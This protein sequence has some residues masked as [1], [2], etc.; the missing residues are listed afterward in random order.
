MTTKTK[1]QKLDKKEQYILEAMNGP[2]SLTRAEAEDR[3]EFDMYWCNSDED[4]AEYLR[5]HCTCAVVE[6]KEVTEMFYKTPAKQTKMTAKEQ[7]ANKEASQADRNNKLA[8]LVAGLAD[9][10]FLFPTDMEVSDKE[11]TFTD[12]ETG[13]G[14][15][16]K[17]SKH[18]SQ[19]VV[20][21][22]VK[23]KDP[24]APFTTI[25]LRQM[26]IQNIMLNNRE[27]FVAPSY[28]G[29]QFGGVLADKKYPF[30]S[31]RMTHHKN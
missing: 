1:K 4:C 15:T 5:N 17:F 2:E 14:V 21:K 27:T 28:A 31:F 12:P 24:N 11:I 9:Y 16:I 8:A 22:E 23:R 29:S 10:P 6:E 25:E 30:Y 3:Y 19:K 13:K 7:K 20:T 26:A 18:K